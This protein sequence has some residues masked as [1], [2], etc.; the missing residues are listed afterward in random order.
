MIPKIIHY[1]WFGQNEMPAEVTEA[2]SQWKKKLPGYEFM[3]WNEGNFDYSQWKF[4]DEAYKSKKY[5]FVADVCRL[6]A[7]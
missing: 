3:L 1:C 4:A 2:I 5:A 7:L 6:N